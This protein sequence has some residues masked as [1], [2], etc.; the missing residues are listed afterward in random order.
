MVFPLSLSTDSRC[1][2]ASLSCP[3]RR[4]SCIAEEILRKAILP[5]SASIDALH[6]TMVAYQHVDYPLTWNCTHIANARILS[7]VYEVLDHAGLARPIICTP[8]ELLR[9]D[10]EIS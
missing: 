6:V 1:W 4:Q 9:D 3:S 7:T 5:R 8:D 2:R 10:T